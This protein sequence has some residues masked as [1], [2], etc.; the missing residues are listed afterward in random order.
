MSLAQHLAVVDV[1]G[2]TFAPSCYV[3]GIHFREFPYFGTIGLMSHCTMWTI[4]YTLNFGIFSLSW[5]YPPFRCVIK[6]AYIQQF[7]VLHT[8]QDE[9]EH[10]FVVV[11]IGIGIEFFHPFRNFQWM[12]GLM[13]ILLVESSP[14]E[15]PH[16]T[17]EGS[18]IS[19]PRHGL[20]I[21]RHVR[22]SL[23]GLRHL[24]CMRS[25]SAHWHFGCC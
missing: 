2:S 8:S 17:D 21:P 23:D 10:S 14:L 16:R 12:I 3:V 24:R 4:G 11:Y 6:H 19:L 9:F 18:Y 5:V 25:T 1:C 20:P 22:G 7:G 15:A 13:M